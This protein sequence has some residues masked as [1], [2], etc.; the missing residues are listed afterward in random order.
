MNVQ[1]LA[2]EKDDILVS[3]CFLLAKYYIYRCKFK[4]TSPSIR[5]YVQQL[6][7][8]LEIEKQISILT[9]SQNEFQQKWDKILLAL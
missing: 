1:V 3:H 5:E 4:N 8:N 9:D 7:Y 6:K 2:G